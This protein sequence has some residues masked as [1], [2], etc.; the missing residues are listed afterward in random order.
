VR[1]TATEFFSNSGRG[2]AV[3]QAM[4]FKYTLVPGMMVLSASLVGLAVQH[5]RPANVPIHTW[6]REDLFAGF[7][8]DDFD[9]YQRG[10][11]KV[12]EYLAET[13]PRPEAMA[14][15]AGGKLYRASRAFREGKTTDGDTLIREATALMDQA[16][17]AA[18]NNIGVH[19]TIGGSIVQTANRLPERYYAELMQRGRTHFAKLYSVQSAAVPQLPLHIKGELLAGVAETEFRV[20]D[21]AKATELL[22]QIVKELPDTGY[23]KSAAMFLATPEKVTRDT[24]LVCH[25]CHEP[26]RLSAWESRQK[27]GQ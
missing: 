5:T 27:T 2:D 16:V 4:T 25:S 11:Q 10:E 20:G 17:A 19:A 1:T 6:V 26:G 15:M 7:I 23:A 21:R 13:P 18:P 8:D 24:K 3:L 9:R 14:W 22:N 12:L